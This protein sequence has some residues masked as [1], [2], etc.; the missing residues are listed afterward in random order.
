MTSHLISKRT[1]TAQSRTPL[2]NTGILQHVLGYAGTPSYLFIGAVSSFWK[3]C[4]EMVA[5]AEEKRMSESCRLHRRDR[6]NIV[7]HKTNYTAAFQS[8]ATLT[9]AYTS[10]LHL[11]ADDQTLQRAA[12][13]RASL[14]VLAVLHELGLAFNEYTLAGAV[15]S[16][17]EDI[18]DFLHTQHNCPLAWH[19]GLTAAGNGNLSMLRC[20]RQRGYKFGHFVMCSDAARGGH[21]EALKY[22]RSE[23]CS[24]FSINIAGKAAASGNQPLV[25]TNYAVFR[26]CRRTSTASNSFLCFVIACFITGGLGAATRKCGL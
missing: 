6:D 20:L 21:F 13:R 18:V 23:G 26:L 1:C 9:W 3:Q 16:E 4:Y 8:V 24:W 10:G 12:G 22:L 14:L 7:P 2:S 15:A 25:S 11:S 5:I 19:V 17:R